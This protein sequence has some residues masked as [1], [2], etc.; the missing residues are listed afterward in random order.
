MCK[1]ARLWLPM[2]RLLFVAVAV[3][4][5]TAAAGPAAAQT[6][7]FA[8]C[9]GGCPPG[10]NPCTNCC[11]AAFGDL[12]GACLDRWARCKSG[13]DGLGTG[14][15]R[16]RCR[17]A[18]ARADAQCRAGARK[19][20]RSFDCPGF[21]PEEPCPYDCQLWDRTTRSCIGPA[22]DGCK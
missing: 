12:Y 15:A 22:A 5:T 10:I 16:D 1:L 7:T 13:C 8:R 14:A 3:A 6:G 4:A 21:V 2:R 17:T 11:D 18:C 19:V 20:E 9:V